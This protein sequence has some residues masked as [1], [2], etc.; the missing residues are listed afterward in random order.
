[1][2]IRTHKA[3]F[4]TPHKR[5]TITMIPRSTAQ[6]GIVKP[7]ISIYFISPSTNNYFYFFF[8]TTFPFFS[9][10]IDYPY[11]TFIIPINTMTTIAN[12]IAPRRPNINQPTA[13]AITENIVMR[14][15]SI[16]MFTIFLSSYALVNVIDPPLEPV[17]IS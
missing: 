17:S 16:F 2:I 5:N 13:N 9:P 3:N 7:N 10:V 15:Q 4:N 14:G 8:S 1:M 6:N 11:T 12:T